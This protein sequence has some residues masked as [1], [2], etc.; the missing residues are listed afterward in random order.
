MLFCENIHSIFLASVEF[1]VMLFHCWIS[2]EIKSGKTMNGCN[3]ILTLVL[4]QSDS[5]NRKKKTWWMLRVTID[6]CVLF[7][8]QWIG[9]CFS[10]KVKASV[11][12]EMDFPVLLKR[13]PQ[14]QFS[15]NSRN[16]H[17]KCMGH[18]FFN[19]RFENV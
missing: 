17:K 16:I 13:S 8:E 19:G 10:S 12:P 6:Q 4:L 7:Y 15:K 1:L 11:P 9:F 14:W 5:Y 18:N 3:I 2:N